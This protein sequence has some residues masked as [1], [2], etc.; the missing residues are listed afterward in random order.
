M[1]RYRLPAHAAANRLGDPVG[2]HRHRL[3]IEA[4]TAVADEDRD[5]VL[6]DV[7]E[8]RDLVGAGVLRG[9]RHRLASG[10]DKRLDPVVQRHVAGADELDRD[11][12]QL[13]DL[14]GGGVDRGREAGV[15]GA[16]IGVEPGPQLALLAPGQRS[17]P[18]RVAGLALNER[19]RLQHGVVHASRHLRPLLGADPRRALGVSL[20]GEAPRP[21][22]EH[23]QQG[24][25]SRARLEG[26][27]AAFGRCVLVDED[28]HADRGEREADDQAGAAVTPGQQDPGSA[29]RRR[30]DQRV[31]EPEAAE[32]DC[33]GDRESDE[34]RVA[35]GGE[36]AT[37]RSPARAPARLRRRRRFRLR[38]RMSASRT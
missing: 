11:A 22:A 3:G 19:E 34:S 20:G 1:S 16:R 14:G 18:A 30:P 7:D 31:R 37:G 9:V 2:P 27:V 4:A 38:R 36:T 21:R 12:V 33:A 24:D 5:L 6:A 26:C 10:E 8:G 25:R 28:D 15:G 29:E 32:C 35:A 23:E 17:N 13:L